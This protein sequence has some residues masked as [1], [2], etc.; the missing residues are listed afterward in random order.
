MAKQINLQEFLSEAANVRPLSSIRSLFPAE[1]IPGMVSFLAGKPNASTFPIEDLTLTLKP[2]AVGGSHP[3]GTPIKLS[4]SGQDLVT[5]LQYGPTAGIPKLVNWLTEFVSE[6][7]RRPVVKAGHSQDAEVWSLSVGNGSQDLL[8]KAFE[9]VL[10][11][12]DTALVEAP[13]YSGILPQIFMLKATSLAVDS[14]AEGVCPDRLRKTLEGWK[15]NSATASL[16]F[17]KILYTTP[18]GANPAGTTASEQRKREVL[19]VA[20]EYNII[21]FED[22]PYYYLSFVGL[23]ED[24]PET[25]KRT[26]SYFALEKENEQEWGVGRVLR[27]DSM[28]KIMSAGLRIGFVTGPSVLI[29]AICRHTSISNL[30]PAGPPQAIALALLQHWGRDGF[31]RHADAVATFYQKRRDHFEGAAQKIL[32][33]GGDGQPAVA[34]WV[35]PVAGMFLWLK[36]KL[37]PTA[38]APEGDSLALISEKAKAALVLALPG[39]SFMPGTGT[40]CYVRISFSIVPE[41]Q[42]EVGLQRLR[43]T[44]EQ[45]WADKGL[46]LSS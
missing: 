45:E 23:G 16:K 32:G 2:D 46:S 25:R 44:I 36:L 35:R 31:L 37:P 1:L 9:A 4:V 22:D 43:K 41:D 39:A 21:L 14:D 27:F 3:D 17:P 5:A 38:E 34:E 19:Q 33:A 6:Q 8:G 12:G 26:P 7:H 29:E 42:I 18:T 10:N 15:Q 13:A 28:S 30:Q 40:S 11:P 20:R 24:K